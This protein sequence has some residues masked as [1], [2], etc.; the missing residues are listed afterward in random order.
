MSVPILRTKRF[1]RLIVECLSL[2]TGLLTCVAVCPAKVLAQ[3]VMPPVTMNWYIGPDQYYAPASESVHFG[4]VEPVCPPYNPD[5]PDV[6]C[7]P[8]VPL[9]GQVTAG[10]GVVG[11]VGGTLPGGYLPAPVIS[12]AALPEGRYSAKVTLTA[13]SACSSEEKDYT[14]GP[15]EFVVDAMPPALTVSKP[16]DNVAISTKEMIISGNISDDAS[17][18]GWVNI[19]LSNVNSGTNCVFHRDFDER[20]VSSVTITKELRA[21]GM[22]WGEGREPNMQG[23]ASFDID[24]DIKYFAMTPDNMDC[25]LLLMVYTSDRVGNT[26]LGITRN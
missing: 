6:V 14:F 1:G 3:C 5:N 10:G 13:R 2:C 24:Y 16:E 12:D 8:I 20:P 23:P 22:Y 26:P 17:K 11:I 25:H 21:Y 18:I 4:S 15:K 9:N 7:A 19:I